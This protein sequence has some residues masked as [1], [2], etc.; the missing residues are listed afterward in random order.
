MTIILGA[1]CIPVLFVRYDF[2]THPGRSHS[3]PD[4]RGYGARTI[5]YGSIAWNHRDASG[6]QAAGLGL[7]DPGGAS[8]APHA[9]DGHAF[10]GFVRDK[11]AEGQ[12]LL[13]VAMA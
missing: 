6:L 4:D 10:A 8:A 13:H 12:P 5:E 11:P 9:T 3:P 7:D 1:G 2:A